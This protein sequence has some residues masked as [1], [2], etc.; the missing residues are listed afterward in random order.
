MARFDFS[1]SSACLGAMA[2]G[3]AL[4]ATGPAR[5]LDDDG[6]RNI[7]S[8]VG[9]LFTLGERPSDTIQYRDRAPLV[10]PPNMQQLPPPQATTAD[11]GWM[12]DRKASGRRDP[13]LAAT[14]GDRMRGSLARPPNEY[15]RKQGDKPLP[16]ADGTTQPQ[17]ALGFLGS[18]NPWH[19]D[20]D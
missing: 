7:F 3:V 19:K 2:L 14:T 1:F 9:E 8:S 12:R 11:D 16:K 4:T 6:K 10:I 20:E 17:G 5:A 18:L 13:R 15:F